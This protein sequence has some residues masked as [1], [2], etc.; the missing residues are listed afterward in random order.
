[1]VGTAEPEPGAQKLRE[2][3]LLSQARAQILRTVR[4]NIGTALR[5]PS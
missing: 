5:Q 3:C 1:M 2:L 4:S